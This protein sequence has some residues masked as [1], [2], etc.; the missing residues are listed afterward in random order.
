MDASWPVN[1]RLEMSCCCTVISGAGKTTLVQGIAAGL[2][3]E[4]AIQSPTFGLVADHRGRLASGD[5][6]A[7]HHLDLYR[8]ESPDDLEDL[9]YEQYIAPADGIS[10]IEWPERANDWLPDRFMLLKINPGVAGGRRIER[11]W[12]QEEASPSS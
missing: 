1:C 8:L 5:A 12:H 7:I 3:V 6:V 4:E 9:G 10:L 11:T 2:G